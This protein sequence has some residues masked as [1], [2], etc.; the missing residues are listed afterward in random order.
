MD[1]RFAER[2]IQHNEALKTRMMTDPVFKSAITSLGKCWKEEE[3]VDLIAALVPKRDMEGTIQVKPH[4]HTERIATVRLNIN[5]FNCVVPICVHRDEG[6]IKHYVGSEAG[7]YIRDMI[8][9]LEVEQ[10][11]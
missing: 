9:G 8:A 5:E 11:G 10:D 1:F 6:W 7:R 2:Y 4:P 3:I